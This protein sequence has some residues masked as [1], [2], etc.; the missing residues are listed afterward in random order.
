MKI[1]VTGGAGYVGGTVAELLASQGHQVVVVDNLCHASRELVPAGV[2][3]V[4]A[5]IADRPQ[6]EGLFRDRKSVV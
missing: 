3:F 6:I 5:D 1:M 4:E 2:E